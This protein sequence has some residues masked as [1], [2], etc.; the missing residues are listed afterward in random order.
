MITLVE[1]TINVIAAGLITVSS[2]Q[3][4]MENNLLSPLSDKTNVLASG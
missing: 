4:P 2:L 1:Q 3:L